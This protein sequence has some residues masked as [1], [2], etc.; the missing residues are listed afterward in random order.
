MMRSL[1]S[2]VALATV[3]AALISSGSCASLHDVPP[4]PN[5]TTDYDGQWLAARA[6]WYG[7]PTGA[8]P[9]DNGMYRDMLLGGV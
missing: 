2:I 1:R 6:T 3:L 4:G 9:D 7:R 8:G 5:I